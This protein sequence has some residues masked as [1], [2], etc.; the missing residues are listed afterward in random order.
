MK[1]I[2]YL[3]L[4]LSAVLLGNIVLFYTSESY[5]LFLRQVKHTWPKDSLITDEYLTIDSPV[6]SCNCSSVSA[7]K[8]EPILPTPPATSPVVKEKKDYS[9]VILPYLNYFSSYTMKMKNYDE[10]YSLFG[11]SDEYPNDY[12]TYQTDYFELY[13]FPESSFQ[14]LYDFFEVLASEK[15][16]TLNKNK[17]FGKQSFF[18]NLSQNDDQVRLVIDSG[19]IVVWLVIKKQHYNEMKNILKK[20]N[21]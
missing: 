13:F 8:E 12:T 11:I 6:E 2:V 4:V 16:F 17:N 15:K 7:Q 1:K 14:E 18:I 3:I 19:K 21:S 10:Y 9:S 5:N 20:F